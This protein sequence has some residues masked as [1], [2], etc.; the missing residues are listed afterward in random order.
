MTMKPWT[1]ARVRR[2]AQR[3]VATLCCI[4]A[5]LAGA[6][7]AAAA[8][9]AQAQL[10]LEAGQATAARALFEQALQADPESVDARLGLGRAYYALGEYGRAT[11]EF[12][13]VFDFDNAPEDLRGTSRTPEPASYAALASPGVCVYMGRYLARAMRS[14]TERMAGVS[15]GYCGRNV[16]GPGSL[17]S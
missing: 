3:G 16:T 2:L 13:A 10:L 7:P 6:A 4:G 14:S 12:E 5:F 1:Y 8:D 9:I 11:I 15:C 17:S